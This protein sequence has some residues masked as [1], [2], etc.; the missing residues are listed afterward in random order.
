MDHEGE[1]LA[2]FV[3][4]RRDRMAALKFLKRTMK[5]CGRPREIVTDRL[6]SY[7]A[8]MK[9]IGNA[10]SQEYTCYLNNR[11]ENSDQLFRRREKAIAKVRG[12]KA[13][14]KF[15]PVQASLLNH[16]NHGCHLYSR[17]MFKPRCEAALLEWRKLG[18]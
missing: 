3:T 1:M 11:A 4:K 18:V 15:A 10:P 8:A 12:M 2:V 5:R 17:E 13:L 16:F 7:K 6:G 9:E 14:Q